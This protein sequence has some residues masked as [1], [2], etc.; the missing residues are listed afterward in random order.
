MTLNV[1]TFHVFQSDDIEGEDNV[2][3]TYEEKPKE[4]KAKKAKDKHDEVAQKTM[5]DISKC[6]ATVSDYVA[7][8]KV[9]GHQSTES[10]NEHSMWAQVLAQKLAKV[11]DLKAEEI[12]LKVDTLVLE[13]LRNFPK[14]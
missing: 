7:T 11:D 8:Q 14:N 10:T 6:M 9:S 1:L 5:V 4:S 13:G 12:K 3:L 2:D